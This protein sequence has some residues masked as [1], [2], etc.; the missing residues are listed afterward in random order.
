MKKPITQEILTMRK[1]IENWEDISLA[2]CEAEVF[3]L[4]KR[5]FSTSKANNTIQVHRLQ[6]LLMSSH[7]AKCLAVAKVTQIN[8]GRNT[9]GIDG[10]RSISS[11]EKLRMARTLSLGERI[12]PVKRVWIPKPGKSERRPLGIPTLRNR[13]L[14]ALIALALEPQWEARF[15]PGMYGFRPGRGAHDAISSIRA[16]IR[17]SPKWVLDADIEKF[18]DRVNHEALLEKLSTFPAMRAAIRRVLKSGSIDGSIIEDSN[19]GTPQG[20]PLSPLLANIVL[21]DLQTEL[22]AACQSW[23]Q[24]DRK[25]SSRSPVVAMYADDFVVLHKDLEVVQR[26]RDFIAAY[27]LKMG[28]RLHPEKTRI[29]HTMDAGSDPPGFDFLGHHIRQFQTGKYAVKASFKQVFTSITPSKDSIRRVYAKAALIIEETLAPPNG[30]GHS[31]GGRTPEEILIFRL[32]PVI[33]GWANYFRGSNA[34]AAFSRLDHLLWWK[35][36][37]ALRRRHKKHGRIWTVKNYLRTLEG[38]WRF[39][40]RDTSSSKVLTLRLFAEAVIIKH[41][42]IKRGASFYDGDWTYWATRQGRYPGVPKL[43]TKLLRDQHGYCHQCKRSIGNSDTVRILAGIARGSKGQKPVL[44][45][46][47]QECE[48]EFRRSNVEARFPLTLS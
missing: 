45:L 34:K 7:A 3:H 9:A 20:G 42:Q 17:F 26:S 37:K 35:I 21:S 25:L 38:K 40:C 44:F 14:Q 19:E 16:S 43:I 28:L 12:L 39:Q 10:Q 1:S 41:L 13:A 36:W 22:I 46:V 11:K 27:L 24:E 30:G 48:T 15:T 6:K 47:H 32:N 23:K 33:R 8:T 5:I 18:F 29:V 31:N 2:Q 4:Q